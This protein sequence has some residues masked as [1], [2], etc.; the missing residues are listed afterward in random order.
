[1]REQWWTAGS[2]WRWWW[3]RRGRGNG[4]GSS[5]RGRGVRSGGDG[6]AGD[7][8]QW[9]SG[10]GAEERIEVAV[11]GRG[12]DIRGE[13]VVGSGFH[14]AVNGT[15]EGGGLVLMKGEG[16]AAGCGSGR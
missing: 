16:T 5:S 9:H 3:W 10:K 6:D 4:G 11:M 13:K 1:M 12:E 14:G 2:K 7:G 15:K 8:F